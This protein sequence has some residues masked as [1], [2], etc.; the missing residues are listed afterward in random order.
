MFVV[1]EYIAVEAGALEPSVYLRASV[2]AASVHIRAL[3]YICRHIIEDIV[4][5]TGVVIGGSIIR[6]IGLKQRLG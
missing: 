3:G 2:L 6:E 4:L 5:D 1:C